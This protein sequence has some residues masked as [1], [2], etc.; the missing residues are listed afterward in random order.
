VRCLTGL[1]V[2]ENLIYCFQR[3]AD[4]QNVR[5]QRLEKLK[6]RDLDTYKAVEWLAKNRDRFTG[7][8]YEPIVLEM[9]VKDPGYAGAIE[10]VLGGIQGPHLKVRI[11]VYV[12]H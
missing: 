10:S 4:L 11:H 2:I 3:L 6:E 7:N 8:V 12:N 1:N 5:K 9:N